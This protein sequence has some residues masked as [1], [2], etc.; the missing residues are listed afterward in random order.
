[1][2]PCEQSDAELITASITEP[3]EFAPIFDRHASAVHRYLA[4]RVDSH[5]ADDLLSEVF[6]IAFRRRDSYD[7][8]YRDARPWL[9]GIAT[10]ALHHHRRA[11]T[12]RLTM[13]E[14]V[15]WLRRAQHQMAAEDVACDVIGRQ[16][17]EE[18]RTALARID[19]KFVDVL[20]LFA[21]FGLSYEEIARALDIR[22]GTV[23]SRLSRG[24]SQLREL[25]TASGQY[26]GEDDLAR[27][28]SK[29]PRSINHER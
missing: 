5:S 26:V 15:R 8:S 29:N 18:I 10:N 28:R 16:Q 4:S 3:Q 25:L 11:E 27:V 2:R 17:V 9:L 19:Q 14:R 1:M 22:I 12:R 20:V 13:V 7:P 6:V 23:R 21:A 24:R